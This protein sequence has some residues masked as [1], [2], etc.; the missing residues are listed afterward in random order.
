MRAYR[1][2]DKFGKTEGLITRSEF[3]KFLELLPA[4]KKLWEYFEKIDVDSDRR[5]N[6]EE[7]KA[8][9]KSVV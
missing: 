6:L 2:A 7:F 9:R 5:V 3:R 4:Y 1:K 8:E